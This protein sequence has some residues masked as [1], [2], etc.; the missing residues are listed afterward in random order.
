MEKK[1]RVLR[2]VAGLYKVLG[3]LIGGLML[4][5]S[6]FICGVAVIGGAALPEAPAGREF[7]RLVG[8]TLGGVLWAVLTILYGGLF[9]LGSY[10]F[11]EMISLFLALEENTRRTT[12]VLE[13]YFRPS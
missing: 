6:L 13:R 10:A 11:G 1:F 9:A 4:L 8:S 12:A 3:I 2:F 7:A 5:A